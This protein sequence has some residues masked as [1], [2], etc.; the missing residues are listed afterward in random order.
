M[1]QQGFDDAVGRQY[2]T[3][4]SLLMSD[5][6]A[7]CRYACGG[8]AKH[9]VLNIFCPGIATVGDSLLVLDRLVFDQ[10]KLGYP[11][12]MQILKNDFCGNERLLEEIGEYV[13]FGNDT[14]ND[15]YTVMAATS[16]AVL[17]F[18]QTMMTLC[19]P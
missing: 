13:M 11:A 2:Y 19:S 4:D 16:L 5:T 12:L 3:F 7:E 15:A 9:L 8:D 18:M 1:M 14:E 17:T 6:A 10:K